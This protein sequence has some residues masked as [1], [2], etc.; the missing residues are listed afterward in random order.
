MGSLSEIS[1]IPLLVHTQR[2]MA[3][4]ESTL[5][6][7]SAL[8]D[9][10]CIGLSVDIFTI[11]SHRA[12]VIRLLGCAD[13]R[14]EVSMALSRWRSKTFEA[15]AVDAGLCVTALRSFDEWDAH[16]Q[17][18]ALHNIPPVEILKIGDAPRKT[19]GRM[20]SRPLDDIRVLD[21]TRVIAGPVAGKILAG[22]SNSDP[23]AR[24][25]MGIVLLLCF[26]ITQPMVPTSC[27]SHPPS[28]LAFQI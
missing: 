1:G 19:N 21:L 11:S 16:P 26:S 6:F 12:G 7:L 10:L 15:G 5:I 9:P 20:P 24:C 14:Q 18:R 3:L 2:Q 22:N 23:S 27:L 4:F 8:F 28:F 25:S 13:T 17:G